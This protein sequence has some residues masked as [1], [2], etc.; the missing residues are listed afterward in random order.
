MRGK[1]QRFRRPFPIHRNGWIPRSIEG[2][3]FSPFI[4]TLT[5]A[6]RYFSTENP[7]K[8]PKFSRT[9]GSTRNR[10][11]YPATYPRNAGKIASVFQPRLRSPDRGEMPAHRLATVATNAEVI[12]PTF[13]R[14]NPSPALCVPRRGKNCPAP[15]K[16][17]YCGPSCTQLLA[18]R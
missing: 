7:P 10:L 14:T 1:L 15:D 18:S 8:T 16:P 13:L 11:L 5:I 4:Q 6:T 9:S 2:R 3:A 12:S 17:L